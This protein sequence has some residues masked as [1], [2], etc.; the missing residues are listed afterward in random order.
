M[1]QKMREQVI[2]ELRRAYNMELETVIN[3]VANSVH[4]DGVRAEQIRNALAAD[5]TEELNHATL[6]AKRLKTLDS[7]I[8]GSMEL[9]M[10]QKSLQPPADVT[11]VISVIKG[12]IDAEQAAIDQYQKIITMCEEIDYVT[13][14]MCITLMGDEEEHHRLFRGYLTEFTK[15]AWDKKGS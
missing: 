14:D 11:D 2:R 6:L 13:Q 9:K 4:L 7:G 1:D 10:E 8:P 15:H 5:I 12:V 3:Y